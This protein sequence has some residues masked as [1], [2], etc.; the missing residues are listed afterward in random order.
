MS[1]GIGKNETMGL[2]NNPAILQ[3][4]L[5]IYLAPALALLV[6]VFH[7][8]R[9]AKTR[10]DFRAV[11]LY[12]FSFFLALFVVPL[13]IVCLASAAPGRFLLSLG[14]TL[15][16]ISRGLFCIAVAV[17]IAIVSGYIGSRD[18]VM[19]QQYPFSK[20]ACSS[21]KKFILYETAYLALYYLPWEFVF[22]GLL[23]FPL[24]SSS[25]LLTALAVQTMISTLYHIGH[26]DSEIFAA[27]GAGFVFGL[28]AYS[29]GS[30]FYT[31][32]IHAL[33]GISNDAFIYARDYRR[34]A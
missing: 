21:L 19:R 25:G 12:F 2:L 20:Q 13:L 1:P 32:V 18:P 33:V 10:G 3:P 23:F 29:T 22:R 8:Q 31:V 4:L 26:S 15:G 5:F 16:R 24:I 30:F 9:L 17:P 11:L 27:L 7:Y 6:T 14:W 28:I 34:V